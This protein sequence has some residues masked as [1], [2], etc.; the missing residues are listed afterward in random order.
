MDI[1]VQAYRPVTVQSFGGTDS[2][3][4]A[5]SDAR[6]GGPVPAVAPIGGNRPNLNELA[7]QLRQAT[8]QVANTGG[9][10]TDATRGSNL[11]ILA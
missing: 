11:N 3:A 9:G 1:R 10:Y 8:K 7:S 4:V 2:R 6:Q 5:I